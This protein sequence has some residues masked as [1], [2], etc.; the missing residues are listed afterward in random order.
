MKSMYKIDWKGKGGGQKIVYFDGPKAC[1]IHI[2]IVI[3]TVTIFCSHPRSINFVH[4]FH[5]LHSPG[6]NKT[7]GLDVTLHRETGMYTSVVDR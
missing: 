7:H 3:E 2:I 6:T 5:M 4:G 1:T